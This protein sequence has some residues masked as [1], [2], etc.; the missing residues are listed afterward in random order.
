LD[1]ALQLPSDRPLTTADLAGQADFSL[2]RTRVSPPTRTVTGPG[3][4]AVVEPRVM[5]VLLVLAEN[6]GEVVT[7]EHL[8]QRCW[9]G[10]YVGD[11]SLNRAV[12]A[13]R[14]LATGIAEN[15]FIIDTVPRTGYRL[16]EAQAEDEKLAP[17]NEA[18]TK[19]EPPPV[20]RRLAVLGGAAVVGLGTGAIWIS[21]QPRSSKRFAA[22]MERGDAAFRDGSFV[23]DAPFGSNNNPT[24]IGL[25]EEAVRL[26][27]QSARAWGL[28]AY[29]RS[30]RANN[31]ASSTPNAVLAEAQEAITRALELDPAEPNARVASLILQ[32]SL[33]G[34]IERDRLLRTVLSTDPVNIPAMLE[35]MPLLQATGLTRES[36]FWNERILKA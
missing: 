19:A 28:L 18:T 29:F 26:E 3:G 30:N 15:S 17:A 21:Q 5:Q 9:G 13:V 25:Y 27:P 22:L 11:D 20:S 12:A 31:L 14:K 7:R 24:L 32:D 6:K 2:G 4:T 23:T 8:F 10:I 33:L 34:L 16:S 1:R 36:W 35:L